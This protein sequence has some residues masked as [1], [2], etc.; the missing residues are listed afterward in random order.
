MPNAIVAQEVRVELKEY[1]SALVKRG[2]VILL[3]AAVAAISAFGISQLQT[4]K[5]RSTIDMNVIPARLDWGLQETI[6]NLLRNYSGQIKSRTMAQDVINRAQLDL[7]IDDLLTK[8]T[9]SPVESDFLIR[10]VTT[11]TDPKRAQLIAQTTAEIFAENVRV[12]ML[13]QDKRDR[14]DVSIQ[15]EATEGVVFWPKPGLLALAAGVFGLLAGAL[16]VVGL[17]WLST[18]IMRTSNDIERHAELTVLGTI[19]FVHD[20]KG[21]RSVRA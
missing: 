18:D 13:E 8:M 2:W 17:Q 9:V 21:H 10:I 7:T 1:L 19:P 16:V 12:Y 6:K 20:T 4:V 14:V 3:V 11:D 15:D 5:Y